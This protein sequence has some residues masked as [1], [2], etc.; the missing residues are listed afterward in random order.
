MC[1]FNTTRDTRSSSRVCLFVRIERK[2]RIIIPLLLLPL[3]RSTQ[4]TIIAM[5]ITSKAATTGTTRFKL[6]RMIRI[7]SSA[8]NSG[9]SRVGA[10][11][12]ETTNQK[13]REKVKKGYYSISRFGFSVTGLNLVFHVFFFK[14]LITFNISLQQ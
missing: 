3:L 6:E 7:V 4:I 5:I 1:L 9:I 13:E 12:P 11:V 10:I 8:V 2:R 14:L